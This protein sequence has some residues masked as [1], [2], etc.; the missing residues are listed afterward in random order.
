MPRPPPL[1]NIGRTRFIAVGAC[2]LDTILTVPHFPAPDS[3]LRATG[4]S[5]RGGGNAP[6]TL[7]VLQ[8]LAGF[9]VQSQQSNALELHLI[10]TLPSESCAQTR[11]LGA[12]FNKPGAVGVDLSHCIF[13]EDHT[14]PVSSYIISDESTSTRTIV[15]HNPLPEMEGE[16]FREQ[17]DHLLLREDIVE[18]DQIW[19][20]FEGRI[21]DV[22]FA[23]MCYLRSHD[24]FHGRLEYE[25]ARLPRMMI[26]VELEKPGREGLQKL[27]FTA[28]MTF[29]SR[30]WAESQGYNNAE[31]CVRAQGA[32]LGGQADMDNKLL[33]CTWGDKAAC[34]LPLYE[35]DRRLVPGNVVRSAA[36]D[37]TN[38]QIVDSTGAGDTFIAGMLF[39]LISRGHFCKDRRYIWDLPKALRFANALAGRK[40]MQQG[41]GGLAAH[42][43]DML[44]VR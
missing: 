14:E 18:F 20:H 1:P 35:N 30:A 32:I 21:P 4:L 41:F 40:I 24:A 19:I 6:N 38:E 9:D 15:N 22:T 11:Y 37:L 17:I 12:S 8:Q 7:E 42:L 36:Q 25:G 5:K 23:C 43:Q 29:Y 34:A 3:K 31:M 10:A 44:L 33:M 39:G 13:R 16:E 27:A 2:A 28:D 26:S